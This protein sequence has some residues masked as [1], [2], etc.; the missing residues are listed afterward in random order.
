M[1]EVFHDRGDPRV[2]VIS[3]GHDF[4][5]VYGV[6]HFMATRVEV[7]NWQCVTPT[8]GKKTEIGQY[9]GYKKGVVTAV[10][11]FQQIEK[12]LLIEKAEQFTNEL[13][14]MCEI[15]SS[16]SIRRDKLLTRME[17]VN[18]EVDYLKR[19]K[20]YEITEIDLNIRPKVGPLIRARDEFLSSPRLQ[21]PK[22]KVH[23]PSETC[24][25]SLIEEA[26]GEINDI[27]HEINEKEQKM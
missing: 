11:L 9:K 12:R 1:W 16:L 24:G 19:F 18:M 5:K 14:D 6:S 4:G 17:M 2:V 3:N 23:R 22:I 15:I 25:K 27:L 13:N 8:S 7:K 26:E 10:E 21:I 20:Q